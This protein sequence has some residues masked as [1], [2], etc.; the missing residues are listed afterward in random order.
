MKT[1]DIPDGKTI[2]VLGATGQQGGAVARALL[3]TGRWKLRTITRDTTSPSAANLARQGVDVRAASLDEP[4]SLQTAFEGAYG[5]YSVQGTDGGADRELRRG[6]AVADAA[7]ANRIEHFIYASVG[8]ADRA[9]GV[10]HFESKGRIEQHV[11]NIGLPATI[12]R[13]TFFMDNFSR[14]LPRWVL[15]ALMRSYLP[16]AKPLQMIAVDD[17]GRW[18]VRAF[19]DAAA[20]IGQAEEIAGDEL[21]RA[22]IVAILRRHGRTTGLPVGVPRILRPAIP[23]DFLKMFE[24]FARAGYKAD[25]G[26][27]RAKQP[28]MMTFDQWLTRTDVR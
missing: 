8:G 28:D 7:K 10:P 6:I 19:D 3:A 2:V 27:L 11:R 5:V 12:V 4:G 18:A 24:W 23:D 9:P 16:D 22:E 1:Q 20:F 17:I 15:I 26:A 13:P 21:T 14:A 25:V